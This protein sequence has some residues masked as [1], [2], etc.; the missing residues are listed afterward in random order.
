MCGNGTR[1]PGEQCDGA[2][3]GGATCVSL[4]FPGGALTCAA[5]CTFDT[6]AC[7]AAVCGDGVVTPGEACDPGGVGGSPPDLGGK[8]C[9]SLGFAAGGS[10]TCLPSCTAVVATPHCS[11]SVA[12]RCRTTGDCPAGESCVA[13]CVQCGNGFVDAGEECDDGAANGNGPDRCRP[14]CRPP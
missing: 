10:L 14:S 5:D 1:D 3:L 9:E 11:V 7:T 2:D 12:I 4:G 13:G 6:R 8:T